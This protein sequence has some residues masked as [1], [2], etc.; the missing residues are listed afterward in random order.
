MLRE[1]GKSMEFWRT[2]AATGAVFGRRVGTAGLAMLAPVT[3]NGCD[4]MAFPV[5]VT[6]VCVRSERGGVD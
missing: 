4:L 6:R 5:I 1:T 2:L 3:Y